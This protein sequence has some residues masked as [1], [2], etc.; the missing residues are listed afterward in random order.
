M[1]LYEPRE[2]K[3]GL[4]CRSYSFTQF[5]ASQFSSAAG[6][7]LE[8]PLP[9]HLPDVRP[10]T[11]AN[12]IKVL[13]TL[14]YIEEE[15]GKIRTAGTSRKETK[16]KI[17]PLISNKHLC[18][19]TPMLHA[20]HTVCTHQHMLCTQHELRTQQS[21][22]CPQK[23]I[24]MTKISRKSQLPISNNYILADLTNNSAL[25]SCPLGQ[26]ASHSTTP[27]TR[28]KHGCK[29]RGQESSGPADSGEHPIVPD[30]A[31]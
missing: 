29:T 14:S 25:L 22:L 23:Y 15:R 4:E 27:P 7:P 8:Q 31:A 12:F 1:M 9:Q 6:A 30:S 19:Y 28:P 5:T 24:K 10:S 26:A 3:A 16:K 17:R 18:A 21:M 13:K 20:Q 11:S 2:K